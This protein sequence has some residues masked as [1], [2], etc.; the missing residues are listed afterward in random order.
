VTS[1][2]AVGAQCSLSQFRR[3]PQIVLGETQLSFAKKRGSRASSSTNGGR[4]VCN[5]ASIYEAGGITRRL[6]ARS[7]KMPDRKLLVPADVLD[8]RAMSGKASR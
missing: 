2:R 8:S 3:V 5:D 7:T 1:V 4:R 6:D